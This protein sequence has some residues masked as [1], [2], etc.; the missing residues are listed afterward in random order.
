MNANKKQLVS[1]RL[2]QSDLERIRAIAGRLRVRDSEIIRFALRLAFTKLAPLHDQ[3]AYG[4]DLIPIFLECGPELAYHFE[5]DSRSLDAIVNGDLDDPQ[6]KVDAKDIEIL[7]TSHLMP[8]YHFQTKL[9]GLPKPEHGRL[10]STEALQQ[11]LYEKYLGSRQT[12]ASANTSVNSLQVP[13]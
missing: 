10:D 6:K 2:C 8:S 13:L 1:V 5:L 12:S 11:Y 3:N 7:A 9:N 4:R